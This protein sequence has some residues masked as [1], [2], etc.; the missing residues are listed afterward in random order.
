MVREDP[1]A[2]KMSNQELIM[3]LHKLKGTVEAFFHIM[4]NAAT[5]DNKRKWKVMDRSWIERFTQ[6]YPEDSEGDPESIL[7]ANLV[8]VVTTRSMAKE[9]EKANQAQVQPDSNQGQKF[10]Y[11]KEQI[12]E[13]NRKWEKAHTAANK[14]QGL[15]GRTPKAT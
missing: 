6:I 5:E 7:P 13:K 14:L 12:F 11:W 8:N 3:Q 1:T 15:S 9:V 2:P 4:V 10:Y